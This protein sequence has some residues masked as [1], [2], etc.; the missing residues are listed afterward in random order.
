[1]LTHARIWGA[2]DKLAEKKGFSVSGL[3]KQAGLDPTSF[4]KSKRKSADGKPRWPSTESI[5]KI[6]SVTA[7][8]MHEF[9][10]YVDNDNEAGNAHIVPCIRINSLSK[11]DF[12]VQGTPQG[13]NWQNINISNSYEPSTLAMEVDRDDMEPFIRQG[14]LLFVIPS[15]KR[16]I[17]DRVCFVY[18]NNRTILGD[19]TAKTETHITIA[20][21]A[22]PDNSVDIAVDD[23]H[24][25]GKITWIR[26]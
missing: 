9:L 20:P 7:V 10:V 15:Q 12:T 23:I 8:S 19:I 16:A 4:N 2:I 11:N 13:K 25:S 14:Q 24:W 22:D 5:A 21:I 1:M 6:L 26:Q 17:G 18:Q 3:A